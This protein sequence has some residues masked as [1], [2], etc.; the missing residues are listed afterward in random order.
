M[1]EETGRIKKE[2]EEEVISRCRE[3]EDSQR[4]KKWGCR[5]SPLEEE[6]FFYFLF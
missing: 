5:C 2:E 4:R 6:L 3:E 1:G